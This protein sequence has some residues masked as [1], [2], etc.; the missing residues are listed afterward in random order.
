MRRVAA[1]LVAPNPIAVAVAIV[2]VA[3]AAGGC[4]VRFNAVSKDVR[5]A[6]EFIV[7]VI[8]R[9]R[10]KLGRKEPWLFLPETV[11]LHHVRKA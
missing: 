9:Y 2:G 1:V 10:S 4:F 8:E 6:D 5:H 7:I 3:I 11:W